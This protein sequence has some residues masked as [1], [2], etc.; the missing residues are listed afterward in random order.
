MNL[1]L[2]SLAYARPKMEWLNPLLS[3][4]GCHSVRSSTLHPCNAPPKHENPK[5]GGIQW[6]LYPRV[7]DFIA[8][9]G[10]K[11]RSVSRTF[12]VRP[13][14]KRRDSPK[15]ITVVRRL[16]MTDSSIAGLTHVAS[17]RRAVQSCPKPLIQCIDGTRIRGYAMPFWK[18]FTKEMRRISKVQE[19]FIKVGGGLEAGHCKSS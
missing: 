6:G 14:R 8:Y 18:T 15:L 13:H 10:V 7:R 3:F 19:H 17:I 5:S 9:M 12:S 11:M 16:L 2:F 1:V 4:A